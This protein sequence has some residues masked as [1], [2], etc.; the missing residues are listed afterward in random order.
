MNENSLQII[1]IGG[2]FLIAG[3]TL[4]RT[5]KLRQKSLKRNPVKE[6][7]K[8]IDIRQKADQITQ[9]EV[10]LFDYGREVEGR[11]NTTMVLLDTLIN[12]AEQEIDRLES[13]LEKKQLKESRKTN[14]V[15][16]KVDQVA[17]EELNRIPELRD[18]GLSNEEIARCLQLSVFEVVSALDTFEDDQESNKAA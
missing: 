3:F 16:S 6:I 13:L 18:A 11:V 2:S 17:P 15:N 1:L 4:L 10:K 9:M 7:A 14:E 12:N 5:F 8:E